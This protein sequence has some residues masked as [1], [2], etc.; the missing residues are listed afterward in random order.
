MLVSQSVEPVNRFLALCG[1]RGLSD[2]LAVPYHEMKRLS[3]I[4]Q[5]FTI[6]LGG[7]LKN[8]LQLEAEEIG[9]HESKQRG[10]N[11]KS[12]V[13]K[14]EEESK[15]N[16]NARRIQCAFAGFKMQE[17]LTR[18]TEELLKAKGSIWLTASKEARTSVL[19]CKKLNSAYNQNKLVF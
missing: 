4:I 7:S 6:Y 13:V 19:I 9:A 11:Q 8:F 5:V 2:E 17:P 3:W 16:T 1:K 10:G 14:R 15:K 12:P 18:P